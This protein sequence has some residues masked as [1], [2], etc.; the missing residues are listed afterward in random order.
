YPIAVLRELG[1]WRPDLFANEDFELN[2]RLRRTGRRVVFDPAI[3]SV[4]RPRES[5]AAVAT[6]YWRYGRGK[7]A[8]LRGAPGSLRAGQVLPP[9]LVATVAATPLPSLPGAAARTALAAYGVLLTGVAATSP[10]GW[11]TGPVLGSMHLAWGSGFL[12][13]TIERS[14]TSRARP[15]S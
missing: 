9:A 15:S 12:W 7:A 8:M 13:G 14:W 10:G 1:G 2:W 11:R 4:Y 6:Q 3:W 5:L